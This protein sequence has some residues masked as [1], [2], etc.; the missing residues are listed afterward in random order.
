MCAAL[1]APAFAQDRPV[2]DARAIERRTQQIRDAAAP[3]LVS[4]RVTRREWKLPRLA[5]PGV[6]IAPT[7]RCEQR[8]EGTGFL[9]AGQGL[10]VTTRE[11]VC[12]A[13]QIE[14][15]FQDGTLRDASLL[16]SDGPYCLAVLRTSA[17]GS[18]AP[19]PESQR[20]EVGQSTVGWLLGS[21]AGRAA[22]PDVQVSLVRP[23]PEQ[24]AAYDRYLYAPVAIVR[25]AAGGP[26]VGADGTLLGM[27]V[28]SLVAKDHSSPA[29]ASVPFPRATLFV[30]GDDVAEAARQIAANGRVLRAMLGTLLECDTNRV[31][32]VLPGSPAQAAGLAEG[33]AIVGIGTMT[34][35]NYADLTRALLRRRPGDRVKVTVERDGTRFTKCMP[36]VEFRAPPEPTTAPV[37]GAMVEVAGGDN[38]EMTFTFTAVEPGTPAA[39]AGAAVGD[40]IVSVDGRPPLRF[41]LRHRA[42][43]SAQPPSKIVV[44]RGDATVELALAGQ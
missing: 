28:G 2:E 3:S 34:V 9:V 37:P 5:F 44:Q 23:A 6:T 32:S 1:A 27:A 33:D 22:A 36:L 15:R 31:G 21:P 10:V 16:G 35:S 18:A 43:A 24:G 20:V 42:G 41:L 40:R 19:L 17:P 11:V 13:A 4:V 38:G 8:V 29:S 26:L 30:R 7:G 39:Q 12:D 14:L 25:G